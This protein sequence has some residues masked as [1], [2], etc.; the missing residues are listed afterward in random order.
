M[1]APQIR[2]GADQGAKNDEPFNSELVEIDVALIPCK[3]Q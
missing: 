1:M 2:L 3:N